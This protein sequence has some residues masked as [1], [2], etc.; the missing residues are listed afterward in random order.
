MKEGPICIVGPSG[1]FEEVGRLP[2]GGGCLGFGEFPDDAELLHKTQSVPIDKAFGHF[3]VRKAGN[4][5]TCDVELLPCWCNPVEIAFMG[6]AARPTRH[7]LFAFGYYVLD[8]Q[9]NVGEGS[10]VESRSLLLTL[11][12]SPNIGR[13]RIMVSVV[14]GKEFVCYLQI[15]FVPNFFEQT[16]DY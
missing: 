4:A 6:T 14:W 2:C 3:A 5:Y 13:R 12:T 8:R 15:A 16:T 9:S 10:A 11:G 7:H 1:F